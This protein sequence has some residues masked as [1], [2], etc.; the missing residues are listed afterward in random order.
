MDGIAKEIMMDVSQFLTLISIQLIEDVNVTLDTEQ[1]KDHASISEYIHMEIMDM[2]QMV[3]IMAM[4]IKRVHMDLTHMVEII[5]VGT[6]VVELLN[7]LAQT[8]NSQTMLNQQLLALPHIL[9]LQHRQAM[10]IICLTV[11]ITLYHIKPAVLINITLICPMVKY[12]H[13]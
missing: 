12:F 5:S 9:S 3:N 1:L 11:I 7:K 6:Q 13:L 2:V 8:T 10:P 4:M